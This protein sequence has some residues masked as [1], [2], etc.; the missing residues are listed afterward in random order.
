VDKMAD[1]EGYADYA[2]K[3]LH[4]QKENGRDKIYFG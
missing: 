1:T 2:D 4:W 3:I